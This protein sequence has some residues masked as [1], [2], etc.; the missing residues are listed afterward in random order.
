MQ[1]KLPTKIQ[2]L[3]TEAVSAGKQAVSLASV[4]V[5]NMT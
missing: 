3:K 2:E 1:A 5:T 4:L